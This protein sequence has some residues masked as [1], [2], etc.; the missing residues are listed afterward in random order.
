MAVSWR[1][2]GAQGPVIGSLLAAGWRAGRSTPGGAAPPA[3]G[4]VFASEVPPRPAA[5]VRDYIRHLGGDPAA[6]RGTLPAHFF[7][8]WGFPVL[9]RTLEGIPWDLR[10]V[11][12]GGCQIVQHAPLAADEPLQLRAWLDQVDD[13]GSRVVLRQRLTTTTAGGGRVEATVFAIVPLGRGQGGAKK[14]RPT[15]PASARPFAAARLTAAHARDFAVLTG[16]INP[17]H[18]L[19]PAARAAGFRNVILHGFATLGRGLEGAFRTRF[20]G[21]IPTH[22]AVNVQFVRP[23]ILP[24]RVT[25][26]LG[27]D[28]EGAPDAWGFWA[29][30]AAQGPAYLTGALSVAVPAS[31]S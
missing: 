2:L 18:W 13:N 8:Q 16:D 25:W 6:H 17:V 21:Q 26:F 11:L 10:R 30:E 4:P 24:A 7:P 5:L 12:N 20:S 3:P 29:G 15:V 14:E 1:H 31:D 19:P 28:P 9:A 22:Y 27:P 23:V